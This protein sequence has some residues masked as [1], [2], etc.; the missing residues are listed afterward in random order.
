[1]LHQRVKREEGIHRVLAKN[2]EADPMTTCTPVQVL[3]LRLTQARLTSGSNT[4]VLVHSPYRR[5]ST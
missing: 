2:L 3:L 1:M 4:H 5:G